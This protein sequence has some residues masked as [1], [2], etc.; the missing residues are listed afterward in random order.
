[1]ADRK[2]GKDAVISQA[3]KAVGTVLPV[4]GEPL[5]FAGGIVIQLLSEVIPNRW[6]RNIERQVRILDATLEG[7][8]EEVLLEKSR[9]DEF[10]E[11]LEEVMKQAARASTDE[12]RHYLA[13]FLRNSLTREELSRD[14]RKTLLELLNQLTD[15]EVVLL[16][17]LTLSR[18]E[19][20]AR[21]DFAQRHPHVIGAGYSTTESSASRSA[22]GKIDRRLRAFLRQSLRKLSS[23][24]LIG[25]P[26]TYMEQD[27]LD[28][29]N[30]RL[31]T[32]YGSREVTIF[33]H[34][35]EATGLGT[36]LIRWIEADELNV[37]DDL[38]KSE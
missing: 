13:N 11:L 34:R 31:M 37:G 32:L 12:R 7:I 33:L 24:G 21:K 9:S 23:I 2:S 16:K 19:P 10:Q 26:S 18:W 14:Q 8:S 4:S 15:A 30:H 6:R 5:G 25:Y 29:W 20:F 27:D 3:M 17:F 35:F 22:P 38:S 36:F 28:N 1:M